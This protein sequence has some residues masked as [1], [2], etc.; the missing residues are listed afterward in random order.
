MSK[1]APEKCYT[2][3]RYNSPAE[4]E[5]MVLSFETQKAGGLHGTV[6]YEK[7]GTLEE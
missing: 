5:T 3:R 6:V 1:S 4:G 2:I 7:T